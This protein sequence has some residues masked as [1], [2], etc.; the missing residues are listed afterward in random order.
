MPSRLVLIAA[1]LLAGPAA[2]ENWPQWRGPHFNG[3]TTEQD[4]PVEWSQTDNVVWSVDMPGPSAATPVVWGHRV[5]VSSTDTEKE[6]LKALCYDLRSGRLIWQ[7]DASKGLFKDVRS[8]YSAPSPAT[9]GNIVAFFYGNGDLIVYDLDGKQQWKKN[10]GP[11]AFG[12]T[13]STSPLLHDGKLYLQILQRNEPVEGRGGTYEN[14]S[15]L[16]CLDPGTGK[17]LWRNERP[18]KAVRESLEAFTSP[19]P[20]SH[21]GRNEILVA[22]GDALTGHDPESGDELWRWGTWNPSREGHWRLVPSPVASDDTILVCAPKDHPV[23]AVKAGG[24]GW[25][26]D[27]GLLWSS[28]R[29]REVSSDVPTPAFYDGDFFVLNKKRPSSLSR[30]EPRTGKVKWTTRQLGR[31]EHEASPTAADGKLYLINFDGD[32]T[33]IRAEDGQVLATNPME[34]NKTKDIIRSSIVAT[35]GHL[36]IRT[37]SKLYCVR[38][39]E[40]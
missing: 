25:L 10:V 32:V 31:A 4:L 16:L 3:S 20:F 22:G 38:K 14:K 30:V 27:E 9:D 1:I 28:H 24:S 21:A 40:Q 11:F 18:S 8:Y 12:W 7:D 2:A 36:L 23:Y 35:Q 17:E 5:F 6:T 26:G 37:N 15:H 34:P 33:V 13:F 29:T 19:V 39:E